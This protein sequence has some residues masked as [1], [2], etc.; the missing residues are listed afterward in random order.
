MDRGGSSGS[1]SL[2]NTATQACDPPVLLRRRR[3][4]RVRRPVA[5]LQ[6]Q[7]AGPA[8]VDARAVCRAVQQRHV[9]AQLRLAPAPR[10]RV[11]HEG[12]AL[13]LVGAAAAQHPYLAAHR[14]GRVV[15][16]RRRRAEARQVCFEHRRRIGGRECEWGAHSMHC[17]GRREG[18]GRSVHHATQQG[19]GY[20]GRWGRQARNSRTRAVG[21]GVPARRCVGP[22]V[23]EELPSAGGG[24]KGPHVSK[25]VLLG[26]AWHG[27]GPQQSCQHKKKGNTARSQRPP[28]APP[29]P[30]KPLRSPPKTRRQPS[31]TQVAWPARAR[32]GKPGSRR[33]S[34][35]TISQLRHCGAAAQSGKRKAQGSRCDSCIDVTRGQP[36]QRESPASPL[37]GQNAV[38]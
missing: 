25:K 18:A 5:A 1:S 26:A 17:C 22:A 37:P 13:H 4:R 33:H 16:A 31:H 28:A 38:T 7:A 14:R 23:A 19:R 34:V 30:P 36:G 15:A 32:A 20:G 21:A 3:P 9:A 2:S 29:E 27:R 12:G 11:K 35:C 24:L 6:Q 10:A 8:R